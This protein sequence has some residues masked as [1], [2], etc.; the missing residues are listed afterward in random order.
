MNPT[1]SEFANICHPKKRAF[2]T[3]YSQWGNVSWAAR[4]AGVSREI[5]R[6]WKKKDQE[7]T[8]AFSLAK[9]IACAKLEDE[10]YR[11]AVT[12]T[13]HHVFHRGKPIKDPETG[14]PYLKRKFSDRLLIFL[15]KGAMPEKYGNKAF[16]TP[17]PEENK[18]SLSQLAHRHLSH[19]STEEIFE[20]RRLLDK[21]GFTEERNQ[22]IKDDLHWS[23]TLA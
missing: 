13:E 16:S 19:M 7:Y 15:L 11:R 4:H 8:E 21:A 10:A 1:P 9:E 17:T 3:A 20:L 23:S 14:Q 2:L 18:E 5:H 22:K 6:L 12:G